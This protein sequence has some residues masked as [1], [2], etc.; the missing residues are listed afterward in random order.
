[1]KQNLFYSTNSGQ[2]VRQLGL[3]FDFTTPYYVKRVSIRNARFP[4]SFSRISP[5]LF[6]IFM[7]KLIAK[8]IYRF[9]GV[10]IGSFRIV[11]SSPVH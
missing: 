6:I 2:V 7:G 5:I 10:L 11:L 1:M 3:G 4:I 9:G 8:V